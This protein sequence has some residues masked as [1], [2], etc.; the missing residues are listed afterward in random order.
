MTGLL[1]G[2][3][4]GNWRWSG[5]YSGTATSV[6]LAPGYS[7]DMSQL[8][9]PLLDILNHPDHFHISV[10]VGGGNWNF[11]DVTLTFDPPTELPEP[12]PFVTFALGSV[13]LLCRRRMRS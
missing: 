2:P 6:T 4:N 11:L 1:V 13:A 5:S 7:Q 10:V 3:G 9:A 12:T 8:P